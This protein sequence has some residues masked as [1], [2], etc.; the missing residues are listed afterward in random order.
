MDGDE[1]DA[2]AETAIAI[3]PSSSPEPASGWNLCV[4]HRRRY[5]P[6]E[7]SHRLY[8]NVCEL[9][10]DGPSIGFRLPLRTDDGRQLL[11][12]VQHG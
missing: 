12:S 1:R 7:S 3:D 2:D 9:R 6:L 4:K 8:A 10:E 11:G 5:H